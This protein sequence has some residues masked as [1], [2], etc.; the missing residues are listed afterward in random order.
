MQIGRPPDAGH[1]TATV[2]GLA[3]MHNIVGRDVTGIG[4]FG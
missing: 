1:L 4:A 3:K 2:A